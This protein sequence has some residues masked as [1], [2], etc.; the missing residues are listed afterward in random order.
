MDENNPQFENPPPVS[1]QYE[2]YANQPAVNR[3]PQ[4]QMPFLKSLARWASFRSVMDII[5]GVL[6]CFGVITAAIGVLQIIAGVKLMNAS[7]DLKQHISTGDDFKISSS[8][9]NMQ[10]Y[11][12]FSGI[13]TIIQLAFGL[14]IIILYGILIAIFINYW[15]DMMPEFMDQLKQY[16]Y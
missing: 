5:S 15:K 4:I 3:Q 16:R 14:F 9:Q 1:N 8:L 6:T 11:F 10:K 7:D 12:K 13:A 2:Q